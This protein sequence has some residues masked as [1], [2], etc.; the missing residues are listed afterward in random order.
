MA[1]AEN[2]ASTNNESRGIP[3]FNCK[4]NGVYRDFSLG[5]CLAYRSKNPDEPENPDEPVNP[6]STTGTGS[7][8]EIV[9]DEQGLKEAVCMNSDCENFS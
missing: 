3:V 7:A 5:P 6:K 2:R 1:S 8:F 4:L 9:T